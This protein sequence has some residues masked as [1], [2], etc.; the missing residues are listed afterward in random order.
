MPVATLYASTSAPP[1][2]VTFDGGG[3][4]DF[5]LG[6]AGDDRL[7]GG[8]GQDAISG[9]AGNDVID[10]GSHDDHLL[11]GPGND[12]I[13]GDAGNDVIRGGT[14]DDTISGGAGDDHLDGGLGAN[15]LSGGSGDD[16]Y[17]VTN[18]W[19]KNTIFEPDGGGTDV[20]DLSQVTEDLSMVLSGGKLTAGLGQVTISNKPQWYFGQK[21]IVGAFADDNLLSVILVIGTSANN[22]YLAVLLL[23]PSSTYRLKTTDRTLHLRVL[24]SR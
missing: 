12:I 13:S 10:G 21:N 9:R 20:L 22:Y 7:L 11:G 18:Q 4:A 1:A 8:S 23:G 17:I 3:N 14:G 2:P 19:G 24:K 5:I 16:T 15:T 6:A